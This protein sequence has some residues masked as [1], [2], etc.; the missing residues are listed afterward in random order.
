[1]NAFSP[2][3]L[4]N[5]SRQLEKLDPPVT[6]RLVDQIT[7]LAQHFEEIKPEALR[8]DLAGLFRDGD[9]RIIYEPLRKEKIIVIHEVGHR[10]EIY[11]KAKP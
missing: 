6:K 3:I 10:S 1:V 8:G 2:R 9:Y 4:K 5:A 7:W 11:K